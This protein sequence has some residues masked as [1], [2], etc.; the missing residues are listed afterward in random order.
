MWWYMNFFNKNLKGVDVYFR[1]NTISSFFETDNEFAS[2]FRCF[3]YIRREARVVRF[4][5]KLTKHFRSN[6]PFYQILFPANL[7]KSTVT[8]IRKI[9]IVE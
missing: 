9:V 4:R 8:K 3:T 6:N 5:L 2:D 1:T 7:I